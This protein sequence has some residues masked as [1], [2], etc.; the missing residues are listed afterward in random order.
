MVKQVHVMTQV[1]K[2]SKNILGIS[3]DILNKLKIVEDLGMAAR[4]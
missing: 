3:L 4:I 2:S 1:A